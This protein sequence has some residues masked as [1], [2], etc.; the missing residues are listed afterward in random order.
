MNNK[1][2]T[3]NDATLKEILIVIQKCNG[4]LKNTIIAREMRL[5]LEIE[6]QK[7]KII[8]LKKENRTMRNEIE[9]HDRNN[10]LNND[11]ISGLNRQS[12]EVHPEQINE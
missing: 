9:T 6:K 12:C 3:K 11:L 4:E 7:T 5:Q 8:H 1:T 10:K 2:E